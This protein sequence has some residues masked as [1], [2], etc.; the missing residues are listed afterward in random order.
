MLREKSVL[1]DETWNCDGHPIPKGSKRIFLAYCCS[2]FC[3]PG[4]FKEDKS[5]SR[6]TIDC[7]DCGHILVWKVTRSAKVKR[8]R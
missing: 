4:S 6:H 7:P 3:S 8:R 5:V 2:D 1:I